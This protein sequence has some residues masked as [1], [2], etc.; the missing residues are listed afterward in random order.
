MELIGLLE[1]NNEP[2]IRLYG[3]IAIDG[4]GEGQSRVRTHKLQRA[5]SRLVIVVRDCRPSWSKLTGRI[6]GRSSDFCDSECKGVVVPRLPSLWV[7]LSIEKA[8]GHCRK[9]TDMVLLGFMLAV[10][11][12]CLPSPSKSPTA[13]A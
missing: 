8:T 5:V 13:T 3:V 6:Q 12:S 1:M 9:K 2:F 4:H 10:T 7:T 11:K